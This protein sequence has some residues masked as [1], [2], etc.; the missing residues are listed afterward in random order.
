[1]D[2]FSLVE[3]DALTFDAASAFP[4]EP[5]KVVANIPYHIT[6]PLLHGFLE[7]ERPPELV[8]LLVQAEV[9]ERIAAPPGQMSYLSV[10][11]QNVAEVD[12]VTRVPAAA[13]EPAPSVDS[14]VL[15]LRRRAAA[16]GASRP[17]SGSRSTAWCRPASGSGASSCTTRW[18]RE[19]GAD[20]EGLAR[21]LR[22]LRRRCRSSARRRSRVEQWAC[23]L[24]QL[25]PVL[26]AAA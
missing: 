9:A 15:R 20:R 4:G 7:G 12:V 19:L 11:A 3:A 14:A 5:F 23:L 16:G 26:E 1:M 13:F 6:S 24:T 25:G 2:G 21:G 8:V 10:F 18:R 17:R 22:G